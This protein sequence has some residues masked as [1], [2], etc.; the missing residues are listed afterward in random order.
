MLVCRLALSLPPFLLRRLRFVLSFPAPVL[1]VVS[2]SPLCLAMRSGR[3]QF[4]LRRPTRRPRA[5]GVQ[6]HSAHPPRDSAEVASHSHAGRVFASS[7]AP[8]TS[9]KFAPRRLTGLLEKLVLR[10]RPPL[11][12][13]PTPPSVAALSPGL[14]TGPTP[15]APGTRHPAPV[16][17]T[18]RPSLRLA[19]PR[20]GRSRRPKLAIAP[21]KSA[22]TVSRQPVP[23]GDGLARDSSPLHPPRL[24]GPQPP[25]AACTLTVR[26]TIAP[27]SRS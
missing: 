22:Q 8:E 14:T 13:H 2:R 25:A 4:S 16:A 12:A 9:P 1:V 10:A 27:E 26:S 11:H 18:G 6:P 21:R 7:V 23:S 24:S 15:H 19:H 3:I 5:L 20:R 17:P